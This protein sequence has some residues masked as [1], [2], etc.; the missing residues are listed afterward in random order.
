MILNSSKIKVYLNKLNEDNN[1]N[2]GVMN[3]SQMLYHCNKYIEVSFG[4][5]KIYFVN[6]ILFR[7]FFRYFFLKYLK[8]LEF[9]IKKFK[10]N[11]TTLK[12]FKTYPLIIDFDNE[13]ERLVEN[14]TKV[15]N[16]NT[17]IIYHQLYGNIS[18]NLFKK[19]IAFHTSYHFNQFGILSD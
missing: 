12:V 19:L 6:R 5:K 4:I 8:F 16:I 10:K 15:K 3:S 11:S 2:W 18:S 13:K 7:V 17:K 14:L 1:P 9:D